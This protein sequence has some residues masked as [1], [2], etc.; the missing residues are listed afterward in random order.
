MLIAPDRRLNG[1]LILLLTLII[2]FIFSIIR[3]ERFKVEMWIRGK[4]K[5][6]NWLVRVY[7]EEIQ[8]SLNGTRTLQIVIWKRKMKTACYKKTREF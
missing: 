2:S 8:N 7:N 6:V 3:R 1:D 5:K 4:I